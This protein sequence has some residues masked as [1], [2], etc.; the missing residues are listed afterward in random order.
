M[1]DMLEIN[2]A[3]EELPE[4]NQLGQM[5]WGDLP[6]V[7]LSPAARVYTHLLLLALQL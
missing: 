6:D 3:Y 5:F 4:L 7:T 2:A 1:R